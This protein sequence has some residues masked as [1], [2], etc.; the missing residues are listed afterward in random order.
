MASSTAGMMLLVAAP[1]MQAQ[2]I[3]LR[4]EGRMSQSYSSGMAN[5]VNRDQLTG[6]QASSPR[7]DLLAIIS[8]L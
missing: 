3:T 2:G 6:C 4:L 7:R 8:T 1:G 5:T